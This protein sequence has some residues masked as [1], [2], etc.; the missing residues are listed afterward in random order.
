MKA[1]KENLTNSGNPNTDRYLITHQPTCWNLRGWGEAR[2]ISACPLSSSAPPHPPTPRNLACVQQ[3]GDPAGVPRPGDRGDKKFFL[4]REH[5]RQYSQTLK[6]GGSASPK[7]QHFAR[8][9]ELT[10]EAL[11][12]TQNWCLNRR[13]E[14]C[15]LRKKETQWKA[16]QK[17][18]TSSWATFSQLKTRI[19]CHRLAWP[20][21]TRQTL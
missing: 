21:N 6:V 8:P 11:F 15:V 2:L 5:Q 12:S 1:C 4:Q 20:V 7:P 13:E 3:A 18:L 14:M 10:R 9:T 17:M 16:Q 19:G